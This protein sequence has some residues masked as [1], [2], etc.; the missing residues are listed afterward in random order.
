M[1]ARK[2]LLIGLIAFSCV[3]FS[4]SGSSGAQSWNDAKSVAIRQQFAPFIG[5]SVQSMAVSIAIDGNQVFAE[6]FGFAQ[7]GSPATADTIFHIGS[8]SKQFIAAAILALIDDGATVRFDNSTFGLNSALP[9]F[10][11]SMDQLG[12]VAIG[13]L[14]TMRSGIPDFMH[15][16]PP[17]TLPTLNK[18]MAA[19]A[20]DMLASFKSYQ[21]IGVGIFNYSNTNY[22]LLAHV[23][24]VVGGG[25][26]G[27][28]ANY[29]T[30]M[31]QRIFAR[32]GMND[33]GF[34]N[35]Y[36]N[37]Q[38]VALPA[39][40]PGG[41][42]FGIPDWPKGAGDIASSVNDLHKWNTALLAEQ[43]ISQG[44]LSK[45]F[46]PTTEMPN[47]P[48]QPLVNEMYCM[49]W[50][51]LPNLKL[52]QYY[53]DGSIPGYHSFNA[54]VRDRASGQTVDFSILTS[55]P[56]DPGLKSMASTIVNLAW[57]S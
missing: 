15:Q 45:M 36:V 24:E 43:I 50:V 54:I 22:F 52:E 38:L 4:L 8:V 27:P 42:A 57:S 44:S 6:G 34:I 31:R 7:P 9:L 49:G 20:Q 41:I 29:R 48:G 40:G 28:F 1:T 2:S 39:F 18:N 35:D 13:D 51:F 53:H 23:I 47:R 26:T 32:A 14:L 16:P 3:L 21:S 25:P 5:N 17:V 55:S 46:G 56:E 10:F 37:P 30:F 12:G 33:T 11:S 19:S